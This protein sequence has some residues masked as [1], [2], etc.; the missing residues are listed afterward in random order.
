MA[1]LSKQEQA[2][3][4]KLQAKMEAPDRP[5]V[6]R[7]LNATIDLGDPKQVAL[8]I[9]HGFLDADDPELGDEGG[10]EGAE[11]PDEKPNRRGYFKDTE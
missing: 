2:L 4:E 3:L 11:Q 5:S 10:S 6:G 8:A 7:T 1:Q 9:K